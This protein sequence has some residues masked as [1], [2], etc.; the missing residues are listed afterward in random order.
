MT[1]TQW[2]EDKIQ[3]FLGH[4]ESI[5][6]EFKSGRLLESSPEKSAGDLS[7]AVS[8]F[9]NT[10]GGLLVIGV[11]EERHDKLR[12]ASQVDGVSAADWPTHRLLQLI[13]SNIHPPLTGLRYHRVPLSQPDDRVVFV[14]EV[15]PGRTAHQ[16]KDYRYYGRAELETKPLRDFDIRL[17]MERGKA[18]HATIAASIR[19]GRSAKELQEKQ[20]E[21]YRNQLQGLREDLRKQGVDIASPVA[22]NESSVVSLARDLGAD[23]PHLIET[24]HLSSHYRCNEYS[25]DYVLTNY[26]ERTIHDFE[27][28]IFTSAIA[29]C[30]ITDN[31]NTQPPHGFWSETDMT[32]Y[33]TL[34]IRTTLKDYLRTGTRKIWPGAS[35]VVGRV[36]VLVPEFREPCPGLATAKWTIFLDDALPISGVCDLGSHIAD[37]QETS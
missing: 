15:P 36:F 1:D 19:R 5:R 24:E 35:I 6:L 12:V 29:G 25:V 18:L 13:E 28:R 37:A 16:A 32:K 30:G 2:T 27:V 22:G 31:V 17:R 7:K 21:D 11:A 23:R 20:I 26:G 14:I 33:E 34:E 3:T 10:E 8:A 4:E 9:A